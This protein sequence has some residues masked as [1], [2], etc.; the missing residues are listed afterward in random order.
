V[1][2]K[3]GIDASGIGLKITG[4]GGAAGSGQTDA[5]GVLTTTAPDL[6]A[7]V[8]LNPVGQWIIQI[9]GGASL[10]DGAAVQFKRI[11]SIQLGLDYD[12]DL[13]PEA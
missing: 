5:N 6:A 3:E 10:M 13:V 1:V 2:T 11:Y 9:T 7:L 12:F 4:P 8:G